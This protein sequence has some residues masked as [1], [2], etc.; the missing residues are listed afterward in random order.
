[1][2]F[3]PVI[4]HHLWPGGVVVNMP[5]CHGGDRRFKSDPG[6]HFFFFASV[7]QSVEQ[8]TE[9]PRVGSSILP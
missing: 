6:R 5:P 3:D 2:Q 7:A 1:R 9:N 4:A 8:R